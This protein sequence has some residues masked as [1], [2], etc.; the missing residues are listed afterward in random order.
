MRHNGSPEWQN[1]FRLPLIRQMQLA[2]REP[3]RGLISST[4]SGT[5]QLHAWDMR[6]AR[7]TQLTSGP[8]GVL[9][10]LIAPDGAFVYYHQDHHGNELGHFVRVAFDGGPPESITPTMSPY[11]T[12]G[13]AASA[14]GNRIAFI[15]AV[16]GE[17]RLYVVDVTSDSR[18][19]APRCIF[20]STRFLLSPVLS[21]D[22]EIVV[23]A[24]NTDQRSRR[25]QLVALDV[26][27]GSAL[28]QLGGPDD[29]VSPVGFALRPGDSR[30]VANGN[31]TG[32]Q[33][34]LIWDISARRRTDLSLVDLDG[35]VEA[36]DW[37]PDCL[38][39]LLVH[40]HAAVQRL[41][42]YDTET[43]EQTRL[44]HSP[45]TYNQAC[46]GPDGLVCSVW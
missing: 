16:E 1:R 25:C 35:D 34:P 19:G 41:Y 23:V 42:V 2:A 17:Y 10:G 38:E 26:T 12:F 24:R 13:L 43:G 22:G 46:F 15:T 14:V 11:P 4:A 21:F 6:T 5:F 36:V 40:V 37:S 18:L 27:T 9:A 20:V 28:G 39:L 31:E 30:L 45:G 3:S 29:D 33:R 44:R 7:L 32:V 8:T